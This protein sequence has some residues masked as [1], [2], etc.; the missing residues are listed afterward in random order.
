MRM[1]EAAAGPKSASPARNSGRSLWPQSLAAVFKCPNFLRPCSERFGL[2]AS[3]GVRDH[4]FP[5][6]PADGLPHV[7]IV[8]VTGAQHVHTL[9]EIRLHTIAALQVTAGIAN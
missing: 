3:P 5:I 1:L 9:R 8:I 4:S 2:P 6:C 7:G